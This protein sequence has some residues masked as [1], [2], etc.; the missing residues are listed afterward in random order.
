PLNGRDFVQLT[1]LGVGTT[2]VIN[3]RQ[4]EGSARVKGETIGVNVSGG[5]GAWTSWLLDGVETKQSWYNTPSILPSV[6]SIQEFKVMTTDAPA[7]F[8]DAQ[9]FVNVVTKSGTNNFH[10]DAYEFLRNNHLDARNFFD[11]TTP[12]YKQ[13]QFGG[14]IGG[15]VI[16]NQLFFFFGY[17]GLRTRQGGTII[18][19]VPQPEQLAGNFSDLSTP[20]IDPQTLQPFP[21]NNVP[22]VRFS[23]VASNFESYIPAPDGPGLK[24]NLVVAPSHDNDYNEYLGRMDYNLSSKDLLFGRYIFQ[25]YHTTTPSFA[26]LFG[27]LQPFSG[28]NFTIQETHT[29]GPTVVNSFKAAFNRGIL[30][31]EAETAAGSQNFAEQLGL[32]GIGLPHTLSAFDITGFSG[33]GGYSQEQGGTSNSYQYS[34]DLTLMEGKHEISTGVE[35]RFRQFQNVS[36]LD[37]NGSFSFD[38]RF[39]TNP[40]ADFLLGLPASATAETGQDIANLRSKEWGAYIEDD[41]KATNRLTLNLGLRWEFIGPWSELN[42]KEGVFDSTFPGGRFLIGRQ[43]SDFGITFAP[44]LASRFVVGGI[45]PGIVAPRYN[46]WAPRA[47]LAYQILHN[48]VLRMGYGIFYVEPNGNEQSAK[49]KIPPF[50]VTR[51]LT[52]TPSDPVFMDDLFPAGAFLSGILSPQGGLNPHAKTIHV[53]QWSFSIQQKVHKTFVQLA[54]VGTAGTHLDSRVNL[55][56]AVPSTPGEITP[57]QA[58]RPYPLFG[59]IVTRE[60]RDRSHYDALEVK[61]QQ[62]PWHGL[63]FISSYTYSKAMD[64]QSRLGATEHQDMYDLDADMGL[65]AFDMRNVF[66]FSYSY[67]LPFGQGKA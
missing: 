6:D 19:T 29:F 62:P 45:T 13:N 41:Y 47:G 46:D 60:F 39:T 61:V 28:Q 50:S 20:I 48:T 24:Q 33:M 63:S 25:N 7:Q 54:Y 14:T 55:N 42:N 22:K 38:G 37:G 49:Q 15:P 58:R 40:L 52:G 26:P 4:D 43:P 27:T 32:S 1:S 30:L 9:A 16:H 51:T 64:T 36:W 31:Q 44:E 57:V 18:A 23:K 11:H 59:D 8:G 34:D 3:S 2:P 65:S 67:E 12:P 21:G 10:G 56:Q 5:R 35:A 17:E 53:Q 66:N